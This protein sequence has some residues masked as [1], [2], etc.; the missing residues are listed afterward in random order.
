ME[1]IKLGYFKERIKLG[2][3][4]FSVPVSYITK[5]VFNNLIMRNEKKRGKNTDYLIL[6]I[7]FKTGL[8]PSGSPFKAFL[9]T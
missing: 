9:R 6:K 4:I 1:C 5:L 3:F 8:D 7:D 2:Y